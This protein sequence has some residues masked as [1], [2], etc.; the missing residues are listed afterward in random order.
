MDPTPEF[1]QLFG[2]GPIEAVS[3]GVGGRLL[4]S[5]H[6]CLAVAPLKLYSYQ[7]S[8]GR[9][10]DGF[11]QLFGCGPIE[12]R[13]ADRDP[14]SMEAGFHSCLAVAPLKQGA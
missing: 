4:D 8:L 2:C 13:L 10:F 7:P 1:P 11:P 14:I 5:F 3:N 6:S 12:A 9:P